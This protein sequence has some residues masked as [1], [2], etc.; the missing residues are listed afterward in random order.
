MIIHF[1]QT[2]KSVTIFFDGR[3][4][5]FIQPLNDFFY[6]FR[7]I[8]YNNYLMNVLAIRGIAEDAHEELH[9][10]CTDPCGEQCDEP[11]TE[12]SN[13][14]ELESQDLTYLHQNNHSNHQ[15]SE[16][17]NHTT[18]QNNHDSHSHNHGELTHSHGHVHSH[19]H[20]HEG[21]SGSISAIA[22]MVIMG[23]GLHNLSDGL[24][25]GIM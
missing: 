8:W 25:I 6:W 23:D 4:R 24:A 11:C 20:S 9:R 22:W 21:M 18:P 10:D 3:H 1:K 12:I 19:G 2:K 17:N 5:F 14:T 13:D 16:S 15:A 7:C